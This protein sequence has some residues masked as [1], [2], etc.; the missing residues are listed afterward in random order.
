MRFDREE[1]MT[2]AGIR[3]ISRQERPEPVHLGRKKCGNVKFLLDNRGGRRYPPRFIS[4]GP[5]PEGETNPPSAP[6]EGSESRAARMK[7][8]LYFRNEKLNIVVF[9]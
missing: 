8:K 6:F 3:A 1:K 5:T 7:K 9:L 2:M 4:D